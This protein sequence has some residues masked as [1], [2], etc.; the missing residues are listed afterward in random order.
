MRPAILSVFLLAAA[1]VAAAQ[2]YE[3]TWESVDR[4]PTPEWFTD[5]RFGIFIHWGTYSVPA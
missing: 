4:R 3:P 5:A 2:P 1:S